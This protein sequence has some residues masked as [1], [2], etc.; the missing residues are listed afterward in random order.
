MN[1]ARPVLSVLDLVPV[2]AGRTRA[3]A[4]REML[5]LART[6]DEAG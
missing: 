4:L 3:D 1:A 2:S 6:A 5:E